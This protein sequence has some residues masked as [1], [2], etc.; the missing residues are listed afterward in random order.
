MFPAITDK[1][2]I[3]EEWNQWNFWKNPLPVIPDDNNN[4]NNNKNV[5]ELPSNPDLKSTKDR[6]RAQSL[7]V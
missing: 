3:A 1:T 4:N 6:P 7:Q 2:V 5:E